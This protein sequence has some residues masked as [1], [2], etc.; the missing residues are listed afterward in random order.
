MEIQINHRNLIL[1]AGL[2][3]MAFL[4]LFFYVFDIL[5]NIPLNLSGAFMAVTCVQLYMDKSALSKAW[6]HGF[7]IL[8]VLL[9]AYF[10]SSPFLN[11]RE[12][13]EFNLGLYLSFGSVLYMILFLIFSHFA[14]KKATA[15]QTLEN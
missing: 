4:G 3:Q 9:Y 8:A 1:F 2:I 7:M 12:L 10:L 5:M 13:F 15:V 11:Y 6:H 14:K